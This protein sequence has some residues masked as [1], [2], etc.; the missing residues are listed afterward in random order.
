M[1]SAAAHYM[2]VPVQQMYSDPTV[3]SNSLEACQR[4]FKYDGILVLYDTTL[5][6]EACGCRLIWHEGHPPKVASPILSAGDNVGKLD[7]SGIE[8]HGR[9]PAILEAA[10]RLTL[11]AGRDTGIFGAITG[12]VTLGLHLMGPEFL[13]LPDSNREGFN[14]YMNIWGKI[15]TAMTRAYGELNLDAIVLVDESLASL[16]QD[17]YAD[18]QGAFKTLLN[19]ARFYDIAVIIHIKEVF[20]DKPQAGFLLEADGFSLLNSFSDE[21]DILSPVGT[22]LGVSIPSSTLLGPTEEVQTVISNLLLKGRGRRLFI[23][24]ESEVPQATPAENMHKVIQMLHEDSA[25]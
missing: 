6:A 16:K 20:V 9:I 15:A 8:R 17:Q 14:E 7:A 18:I 13:S 23:T 22:L 12:P 10:K 4:L 21:V 25:Q 19:I 2:Q 24:T 5:E 3:L 1:A 11:T